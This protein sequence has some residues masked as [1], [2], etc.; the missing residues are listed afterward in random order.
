MVNL[1][2][3]GMAWLAGQ[4][5]D[6]CSVAVVYSRVNV[7]TTLSVTTYASL[8]RNPIAT[9]GAASEALLVDVS[10]MDF[11]IRVADLILDGSAVEPQRGDRI[12]VTLNGV[13]RVYEVNYQGS[14]QPFSYDPHRTLYRIHTKQ[15]D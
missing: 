13:A 8:G 7:A 15:I 5:A 2:G 3:D 1:I 10:E 11:L 9:V 6:N 12:A 14:D 4:L